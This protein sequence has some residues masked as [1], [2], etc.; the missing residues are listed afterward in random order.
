MLKRDETKPY[1]PRIVP[2]TEIELA[3]QEVAAYKAASS[4]IEYDLSR[5]SDV[6]EQMARLEK[7]QW[8]RPAPKPFTTLATS[9]GEWDA[10]AHL[11]KFLRSDIYLGRQGT[12]WAVIQRFQGTSPYA[13]ANGQ[14]EILL[15][16]ND[17]RELVTEYMGQVEHTLRFM[18]RN[19]VAQ[20]QRVVWEQFPEDDPAKVVRAISQQ[21]ATAVENPEA[22][23]QAEMEKRSIRQ[24]RGMSI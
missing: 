15:K 8:E 7:V 17:P 6:R 11:F 4:A 14:T 19:A 9:E 3:G 12:E 24:S 18:A 20:A 5:I 16:G 23:K 21:C 13:Q 10:Q 2:G 22:L 1:S